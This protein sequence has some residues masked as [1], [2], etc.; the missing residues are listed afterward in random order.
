MNDGVPGHETQPPAIYEIRVRGHLGRHWADRLGGLDISQEDDGDTLLKGP[1]ADQA[2]LHGSLRKLRDLGVAIISIQM[3]EDDMDSSMQG[4]VGATRASEG[5]A[6][7]ESPSRKMVLSTLWIFA[8]LNY[9]YA[10]IFNAFFNPPAPGSVT[11]T[12]GTLLVLAALMETSIAMV[13]LSRILKRAWNRWLNVIVG[14]VQTAFVTWSLLG[15]PPRPYYVFFVCI[16][17]ATL[18]FIT[19]Y[20]ATWRRGRAPKA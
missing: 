14:V 12:D 18:L 13:L 4:R 3:K 7:A 20:A 19:A 11:M 16:E 10:D 17:T 9:I 6:T 15:E 1:I 5:A 2:A 8:L